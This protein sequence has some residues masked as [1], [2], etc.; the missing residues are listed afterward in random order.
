MLVFLSEPL[1]A[2]YELPQKSPRGEYEIIGADPG[3]AYVVMHLLNGR[4]NSNPGAVLGSSYTGLG[5]GRFLHTTHK[6]LAAARKA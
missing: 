2:G 4:M 6:I 3:T 5:T 1:P